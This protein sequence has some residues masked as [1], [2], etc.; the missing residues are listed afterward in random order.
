MFSR[1]P[2]GSQIALV[3]LVEHLRERG[4]TL[5]D[6]QM[7]TDHIAQ[8]GATPCSQDEYMTLFRQASALP[9]TF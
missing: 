2:Y 9:V 6:A 5:L 3:H 7:M 8:F 1:E 4:F